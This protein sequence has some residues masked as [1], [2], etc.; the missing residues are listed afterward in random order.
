M[1]TA[2][3]LTINKLRL[4]NAVDN[5]PALRLRLARSVER[6]QVKPANAP[7]A[8]VLVV[9]HMADPLPKRLD[10]ARHSAWIDSAWERAVQNKLS[11]FYQQAARPGKGGVPANAVAVVF[12]D[13]A[14]MLACLTLDLIRGEAFE[15][16]WWRGF[17]RGAPYSAAERVALLLCGRPTQI[18]AILH[19]LAGRGQA[20]TVIAGLSSE[21]VLRLL[22]AVLA[23]YALPDFRGATSP[24]RPPGSAAP[25]LGDDIPA[26]R[27]PRDKP[28]P[29]P[30]RTT[31]LAAT[32]RAPAMPWSPWLPPGFAPGHW[33][34]EKACLLGLGLSLHS[35]PA[36]V[37]S[38][39]FLQKLQ[40]WWLDPYPAVAVGAAPPDQQ[41]RTAASTIPADSLE[42]LSQAASRR[43]RHPPVETVAMA[44]PGKTEARPGPSASV[45][46][47]D[48]SASPSLPIPTSATGAQAA[49]ESVSPLADR[50]ATVQN[51]HAQAAAL[52]FSSYTAPDSPAMPSRE[53]E[54]ANTES[55]AG[56]K[57][58]PLAFENGV[59]TELGGALYLINLMTQLD[60]PHCFEKEWGL[61]G[62]L[63]AWGVL[64][65]IARALLETADESLRHDPIWQAL[66]ELDGRAP[67]NLPGADFQGSTT[68]YLPE[69]WPGY[70]G[71]DANGAYAWGTNESRGYLW[72]RRGYMLAAAQHIEPWAVLNRY[73]NGA[74]VHLLEQSY[75]YAPFAELNNPFLSGINSDLNR[76]LALVLPYLRLR[77]QLA[78]R[79]DEDLQTL[80]LQP[81]RLYL[82]STHVDLILSLNR[83]SLPVR[84]A[85]L[86]LDPGWMPDFGR[87]ILFH[88]E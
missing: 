86:D 31:V 76:W 87:I 8:A 82:S 15:R 25:E 13:E 62:Q 55:E 78:L 14:E 73:F 57:E 39:T 59:T 34:K 35:A 44:V 18:P 60:L 30:T 50:P 83:V 36:A 27:H 1:N 29:G 7:P 77:L 61:A 41:D 17:L 80:L 71:D 67:D 11:E 54:P 4:N 45:A 23:A 72:S 46:A 65:I 70:V 3:N 74:P 66:A 52:T 85:G 26:P 38:E 37:R 28:M 69:D 51:T 53:P 6:L 9:K 64:D 88:Y 20:A 68:F 22:T 12:T 33:P 32:R 79:S 43:E 10:L 81:G 58:N 75:D 5:S 16:W 19:E 21:H 40:Q 24:S 49:V 63:G 42:Q 84:M 47:P 2:T 48:A 56:A